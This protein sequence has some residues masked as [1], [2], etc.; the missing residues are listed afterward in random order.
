[1]AE[2]GVGG[3]QPPVFEKRLSGF[4]KPMRGPS[5]T[6]PMRGPSQQGQLEARASKAIERPEPARPMRGPQLMRG[7]PEQS[8]M[9]K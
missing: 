4:T 3:A 8:P 9:I 6:K 1:M 5:F 2:P 7:S